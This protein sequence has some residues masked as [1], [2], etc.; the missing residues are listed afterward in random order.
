MDI[1]LNQMLLKEKL[2]NVQHAF[3]HPPYLLEQRIA[4]AIAI[5][6][7]QVALALLG[8]I[9][10]LERAELSENHLRSV[11]YS[12][13]GSCTIF[14]RACIAGGVDS[15]TA[16]MVSDL[17]IRMVDQ[18]TNLSQVENLEKDMLLGFIDLVSQQCQPKFTPPVRKARNFILQ[19]I[20]RRLNLADIAAHVGVH[21]NYLSSLFTNEVGV[22]MINFYDE[23]RCSAIKQFLSH[24]SISL[25]DIFINF[26]FSSLSYFSSSFKKQTGVSPSKYRKATRKDY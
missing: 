4:D 20:Q 22:S 19:N 10:S 9:N 2:K 24:T 7:S 3:Q 5:A 1:D 18:Q 11:K 17:F 26:E 25:T 21:P 12:L 15:E 8:Q 16:F 6:D 13:I 14:T 23:Q